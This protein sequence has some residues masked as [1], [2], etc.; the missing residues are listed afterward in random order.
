VM[1]AP[2]NWTFHSAMVNGRDASVTPV[3]LDGGDVNGVVINFT[4]RPSELSG[5]VQMESG[6]LDAVTVLV[7]P[8]EQAAWTGYG[9]TARRFSGVRADKDG[10]FRIMNLPAGNY[11]LAAIPDKLASNW[12]DP[13]F[14]ETLANVA[15]RV[16]VRDADK[17]S[18]NLKVIR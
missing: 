2:R 4:D 11:F 7:F 5:Q 15:T 1:G 3:E 9:S 6:Q 13:K 17:I 10:R 12:Q 14:L 16:T 18:Q 8:A